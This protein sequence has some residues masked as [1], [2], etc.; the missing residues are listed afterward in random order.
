MN[1]KEW[2]AIGLDTS[3]FKRQAQQVRTEFTQIGSTA[4]N[5]GIRVDRSF[6]MIGKSALAYLSVRQLSL[7]AMEIVNI[8][9]EF[10]QLGI[11]FETMLGSKVKSD[12]L[13]SEAVTF[14]QKTPFT[15]T[16]VAT[17]IKQLMAMGIAT[18][19]VMGTMKALG[20]VAAG[21]S[22]PISRV[23]INYGQVATLGT[24]QQREIRD[25][26]MAGI[27]L[28][29]E[30][31]KNL[32]KTKS[33]ISD[34]VEAGKIGFPEVEKAFQSMSSEGGKFFN[35][36]EKQNKS[37][38]GQISNLADKYQVAL[39]EIG[40]S[41]EGLIYSG[42]DGANKL[43]SNYKEIGNAITDLI[44]V[45]GTYKAALITIAAIDKAVTA[46]KYIAEAAELSQLLTVEQ[47]A[48]IS[49]QGLIKGTAEHAIA[50]KAEIAA[51]MERQ[52]LL[53][54]SINI[55][56]VALQKTL[57]ARKAER[58]A[59][60]E[61]VAAKEVELA[62]AVKSGSFKEVQAAQTAL[63]TAQKKLN[64][65]ATAQNSASIE[66]NSKRAILD[67]TVR[68]ANT[69]ETGIN[70]AAQSTNTTS[71]NILASAKLRLSVITAKLNA[72]IAA[73][74]YTIAAIAIAGLGFAI[75]KL[76]TAETV[77]ER[78][79]RTYNEELEKS[80]EAKDNLISKT[81][82]LLSVID[83]ETKTL[84]AQIKA[85]KELQKQFP[86]L[87]KDMDMAE[88]KSIP[89]NDR[90]IKINIEVDKQEIDKFESDYQA[91]LERIKKLQQQYDLASG[92][93]AN[94]DAITMIGNK[95]DGE[96]A[97]LKLQKEQLDTAEK[98]RKE[99]EFEAKPTT[100]KL[101]YFNAELESLKKQRSE[102]E[103]ML[104][105]SE[106]LT[107]EWGNFGIQSIINSQK[108]EDL[109]KKID[110]TTGKIS[111]L[112]GNKQQVE[113]KSY[114]EKQ[115]KDA[116]EALDAMTA[117]QKG[118]KEWN[119][120]L[121][122][123]QQARNKL[124]IWDFSDKAKD[125][126]IK[127]E[128][129]KLK[130]LADLAE[131][132]IE[133]KR[134]LEQSKIEA[135]KAGYSKQREE[136]RIAYENELA[137]IDKQ[138]KA[139]LKKLNES[140]GLKITDKGYITQLP[141]EVHDNL[142]SQKKN[143][144]IKYN[145]EIVEINKSAIADIKDI[146][147]TANEDFI[148]GVEKEKQAINEKYNTLIKKAKELGLSQNLVADIE[149]KRNASLSKVVVIDWIDTFGDLD[150]LSTNLLKSMREK[151]KQYITDLS[152]SLNKSELND[153]VNAFEEIDKT[154]SQRTPFS[155]LSE[156][157]KEYKYQTQKI[158]ALKEQLKYYK[159][160]KANLLVIQRIE[161]QISQAEKERSGSLA[162]T[163]ETINSVAQQTGNIINSIGEFTDMLE[164]YGVN[165]GEQGE[166]IKTALGQYVDAATELD[167]T[168]PGTVIS[169][170]IKLWAA[171]GNTLAGLFGGSMFGEQI[172]NSVFEQYGSL[173]STMNEVIQ[174]QKELLESMAGSDAVDASEAA[175]AIIK[176]QISATKELGLS[177]LNSG[178]GW[179]S[180]SEGAKLKKS[181]EQYNREFN[182]LGEGINWNNIIG[183][184]RMEG[185]FEL[186][187]KQLQTIKEEIPQAWAA[188]DERT[189]AYLQTIIDSGVELDAIKEKLNES[190]TDLSFDSAKNSLRDF[191]AD[192][193]SSFEDVT[194]NLEK[195]MRNAL[196]RI[197]TDK[198]FAQRMQEWYD[199][200]ADYMKDNLL[201][202]NEKG[203]LQNLYE[204]IFKDAEVWRN[205][206]FAA[207]GIS[208]DK[209]A[210][211]QTGLT[212]S[213][214]NITEET[215]GLIAGQ[216]MAMRVDLKSIEKNTGYNYHL[217]AI[218]ENTKQ[219]T[220][221]L[222]QGVALQQQIVENT[223]YNR[224][225]EPIYEELQSMNKV[226]KE[227]LL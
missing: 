82:E 76:V 203:T 185:L 128:E 88:F 165:I 154:I 210:E 199:T 187:P 100:E 186:T 134:N 183:S 33:E 198:V 109:N 41:N 167:L 188:I 83:D 146:W 136:A 166:L 74:P 26:A 225:L 112:T 20:D 139:Y 224:K 96:K 53:A 152:G 42:I 200:F 170:G 214:K 223:S 111:N 145:S 121:A 60:M 126:A 5:E 117:A 37:V 192:A 191:I 21:V 39:N 71:T 189:R 46:T 151:L 202:E 160:Q 3:E 204:G 129:D 169:A 196:A 78:A 28:I 24:L 1:D 15:L 140:K 180:S 206:M 11:A 87:F 67:S 57:V 30:L 115:K 217:E 103:E 2:Y 107:S 75:Y 61:A 40:Q 123:L 178:A 141:V 127:D 213:V 113:N 195:Y 194:N 155:T 209:E 92:V 27:P 19:N 68:K 190:L 56:V 10:Q 124:R 221:Y 164:N 93:I 14:A 205:N 97:I 25:F 54:K 81:N 181:L 156:S 90:K 122:K 153:I 135:L 16:D 114:W 17:N 216:F 23:A 44:V 133:L 218:D 85:Y 65:A 34:L 119:D 226:L 220:D 94:V 84:Y 163:N 18:E 159:E 38:T 101:N 55:E 22:V 108:L 120:T 137:D 29:E 51:E 184:G 138:G 104:L 59:A 118:S 31:A 91:T 102:I 99:A 58:A 50:V 197:A 157:I 161:N 143:A 32:G 63:E 48:K 150:K 227:G 66:L 43:I 211:K 77:A 219:A 212:G 89:V 158:D 132:E 35:L 80:K 173:I 7:Y 176:K 45:Y 149:Q 182:N 130:G 168:K 171:Y 95:I 177:F 105:K 142:N 162:K 47:Q 64:T 201:T 12:K 9:G 73:N 208:I 4:Y 69:L 131:Q 8:R 79:H 6:Q 193:D 172:S 86:A 147:K 49:K 13:M 98:I 215:A 222:M 72:V 174:K 148:S 62:T 144:E 106:D 110:E 52:T 125:A 36:M 70:T 207:A 179:F 175:V 116:E